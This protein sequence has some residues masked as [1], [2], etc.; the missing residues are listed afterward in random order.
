MKPARYLKYLV[1]LAFVG[2][3]NSFA[4]S[5]SG[6][7]K[8]NNNYTVS[9]LTPTAWDFGFGAIDLQERIQG[10]NWYTIPLPMGTTSI[11][12][13]ANTRS[14][15]KIYEYRILGATCELIIGPYEATFECSTAIL[16]GPA[17]IYVWP[18]TVCQTG[19]CPPVPPRGGGV[20]QRESNQPISLI[21]LNKL[22]SNTKGLT[23]PVPTP[24]F[25]I[26]DLGYGIIDSLTIG[27]TQIDIA[28]SVPIDIN[29]FMLELNGSSGF[30]GN[31]STLIQF[32]FNY[33]TSD[34]PSINLT[35]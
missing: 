5:I 30:K 17:A 22:G 28:N 15:D 13:G 4:I 21:A 20:S 23:L 8:P 31:R 18:S 6:S 14:P 12:I 27:N 2:A 19:N 29:N 25:E 11:E 35:T 7:G 32:A 9:W 34:L 10:G 33:S 1:L 26:V 16:E 24:K 3:N